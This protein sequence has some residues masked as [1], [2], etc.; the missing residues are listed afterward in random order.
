[1][2]QI[3]IYTTMMCPFC[4]TAKRLLKAKGAAFNEID[5][6]MDPSGRAAMTK[7][8]E[9]QYTVPQIFIGDIH[10]GGCTEL[11]ALDRA[12]KLD[13]LLKGLTG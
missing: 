1:M 2:P 7:R 10:V 5:V 13:P 12:G 6:T 3:D 11:Q 4:F 9:G 8:A